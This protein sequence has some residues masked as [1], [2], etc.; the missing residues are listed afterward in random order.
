[1]RHSR[2]VPP[3]ESLEVLG[4]LR[5]ACVAGVH[6]DEDPH[7]GLQGDALIQEQE[8]GGGERDL[9][10]FQIHVSGAVM[11]IMAFLSQTGY[12]AQLTRR[13]GDF[14]SLLVEIFT[15]Y[16]FFFFF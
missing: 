5:P 8:S 1:M 4:K 13:A 2:G 3:E 6:G 11:L 10:L 7:G 15:T 16:D 12:W 14:C 9:F